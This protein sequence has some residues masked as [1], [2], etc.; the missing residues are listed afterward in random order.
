MQQGQSTGQNILLSSTFTPNLACEKITV[1]TDKL[2][3]SRKQ[4]YCGGDED[5]WKHHKLGVHLRALNYVIWTGERAG[6]PQN[7][8][9]F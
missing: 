8:D 6:K 2:K 9:W 4:L 3:L 7:Q 1:E 5:L